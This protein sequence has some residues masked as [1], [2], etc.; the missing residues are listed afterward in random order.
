M[1]TMPG[2]TSVVSE[3]PEMPHRISSDV[4]KSVAA[5][6]ASPISI[7]LHLCLPLCSFRRSARF[8]AASAADQRPAAQWLQLITVTQGS[9][10][11]GS[12]IKGLRPLY[13]RAV[14]D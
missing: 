1:E 11:E 4:D 6:K 13:V 8:T 5:L 2:I 7:S 10:V 9:G 12:E 3:L 14:R